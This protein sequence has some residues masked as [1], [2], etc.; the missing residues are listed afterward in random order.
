MQLLYQR[1]GLALGIC[2]GFQALV[3]LGLVP[4]GEIR[5]M[6]ENCPTLTFN[7]IGRHQSRYVTT[8]VAS[9]Q[10]P[11]MLKSNV[12]DLHTVPISHGEGRFVAP[13]E[14]VEQLIA[15]GQVATQYVD[16]NGQPTM[17]IAYNP[18]GAVEAIEGIFSPDGRVFGKMGHTER[19]GEFIA[20]N[21]PG[22]KHQPIFESGALYFK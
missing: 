14:V 2:N 20:R 4:F 11:W 16:A 17:D 7:R 12:G 22:D 18:N 10:S 1:D 19:R 21:I 15:A 8:R 13:A 6:D 9:V 5:P 3:K